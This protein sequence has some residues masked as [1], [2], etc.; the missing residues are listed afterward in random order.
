MSFRIRID[1]VTNDVSYLQEKS[2]YKLPLLSC[3]QI[4]NEVYLS[5]YKL[6]KLEDSESMIID[7]KDLNM[8]YL[9]LLERFKTQNHNIVIELKN[10]R[11]LGLFDLIQKQRKAEK[12]FDDTTEGS[13]IRI[14]KILIDIRDEKIAKIYILK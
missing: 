14:I 8:I 3:I 7:A 6:Q 5:G 4:V 11:L 13:I 12:K 9:N 1:S 2:N 10:F